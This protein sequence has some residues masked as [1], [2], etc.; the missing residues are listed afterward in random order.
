MSSYARHNK[1]PYQ[2]SPTYQAWKKAMLAGARDDAAAISRQH[3]WQF[4][5]RG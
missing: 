1:A 5:R 4:N 2:Y 3:R